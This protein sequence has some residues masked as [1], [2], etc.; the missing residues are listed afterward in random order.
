MAFGDC[1]CWQVLMAGT[2]NSIEILLVE[3]FDEHTEKQIR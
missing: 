2:D 1:N 3:V